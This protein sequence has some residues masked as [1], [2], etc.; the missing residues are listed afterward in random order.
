M[1]EFIILGSAVT[2]AILSLRTSILRNSVIFFGIFSLICSLLYLYYQAPD[3]AIAEAVIGSGLV[4]LLYLTALKRYRVYN[5]AFTSSSFSA[6]SDRQ[7]IEGTRHG[8]FIRD[9]EE[10]CFQRELE[11]QFVFTPDPVEALV[12]TGTFELIIGQEEDGIRV[13]GN[14]ENYVVDELEMLLILRYE[15]MNIKIERYGEGPDDPN[16]EEI[17]E[18]D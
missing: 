9:I 12:E 10:F 7:I 3:V 5:I 11:P 2:L 14:R 15:E 6:V 17:P 4:T 18:E 1:F 16:A 13:V 8:Q